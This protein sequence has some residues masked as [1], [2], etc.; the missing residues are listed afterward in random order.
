MGTLASNLL[1]VLLFILIVTC[2]YA[3]SIYECDRSENAPKT[4]NTML[5]HISYIF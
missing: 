2:F 1:H 5:T 3:T 4:Q